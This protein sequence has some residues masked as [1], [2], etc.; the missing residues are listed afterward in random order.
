MRPRP[1]DMANYLTFDKVSPRYKAFLMELQDITIP[2]SPHKAMTISQWKEAMDEE[3]RALLLNN[4]WEIV[5]LPKGKK[6]VGCRSVFTLNT[7]LM[8]LLIDIAILVARGYTQTY[9]IDYQETFAPVAKLNEIQIIVSLAVNLDSALLHYDIKNAFLNGDL[10][11]EIYMDIPLGYENVDSTGKVC[12]L[13]KAL[14]GLKQSP[15]TWFGRFTQTMKT[16]GY[17]LCNVEHKLFMK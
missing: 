9:D 12:K 8:E 16:L 4:T 10:K 14:Y 5:N 7:K 13:K 11:E 1:H 2:K 17:N 6:S 15:R 3:M